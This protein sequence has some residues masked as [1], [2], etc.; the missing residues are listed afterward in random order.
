MPKGSSSPIAIVTSVSNLDI[1]EGQQASF[2]VKLAERPASDVSISVNRT[3]GD[4]DLSVV[5]GATFTISRR[6]YNTWHT[7]T[8]AAAEDSDTESNS[9]TFTCSGSGLTA[10]QVTATEVDNDSASPTFSIVADTTAVSVP[11][12]GNATLQVKLSA[13]PMKTTLVTTGYSS[14][15]ADISVTGGSTYYFD[16]SN[17][18]QYMPITLSAAA[19]SDAENGQAI[20]AITAEG[21]PSVNITATEAD[22]STG[23]TQRIVIDPV[24]R[25]EGHLRIEVETSGGKVT[26]AWSSATMFRGVEPILQGRAP[27]DAPHITQRLCGVCTYIHGLCSTRAIEDTINVTITDNARIVRNLLLGAQFMHDHIVHFY[28]LNG[29]D[30]ADIVS[31]LSA[32]PAVTQSLAFS[33][34]PNAD[35]IDFAAVKARLQGLVD[36]GNLGPFAN[37]YWGHTDYKLSPEEN[38]LIVAHYL[39]ALK[40]QLAAARMMAILGGKNPHPQ[41]VVVGGVTCGSELSAERLT[42]FRAYMDEVRKFVETVYLPDLKL[43]AS[44]YPEWTKVGGFSNFMSYGEFPQ[45]ANEP[46]DFLMPRGAIF[47][48]DFL[49]VQPVNQTAIT[50]HVARSWYSGSTDRHPASGETVPDFTGLDTEDRYTW[51]KAPRYSGDAMEVGPLARVL[52]GYGQGKPEFVSAV[53]SFLTDTGLQETDL[54]STLGRTAARAIETRI[55]SNAMQNWLTE[56]E[57]NLSTGNLQIY[58]NHTMTSGNGF[59]LNE[60]PR[61]AL[62]HW[63]TIQDNTINGYQ[64]VVPSTWNFSP[65]CADNIPGPLEKSLVGV[66]IADPENPVE[67]LRVIHSFDPCIA[68]GVHVIDKDNGK[69]HKVDLMR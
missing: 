44:R 42:Q 16:S 1:N 63:M 7:V 36:T 32:D 5:S 54:L 57:T 37:A 58:E 43:V 61:G 30:W 52:V 29:L 64:M 56:L 40:K 69:T 26:K 67:L 48:G 25:I 51:S 8:I 65:R 66:P 41:S 3:S 39:E 23:T 22:S 35:P 45:G 34:S 9:A 53:Q 24:S 47:N 21:A 10:A 50:E 55:I 13:D 27:L 38:L 14:G 68:C 6:N 49:N 4:A 15:D 2:Q 62:G 19:D 28:H 33:T 46:A 11:E 59:A 20:F 31:A 17:W 12:G 18:D 60:A